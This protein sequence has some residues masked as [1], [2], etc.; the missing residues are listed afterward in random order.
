[1]IGGVQSPLLVSVFLGSAG[2]HALI[3]IDSSETHKSLVGVQV[4]S[5]YVVER[6][7]YV[8]VSVAKFHELILWG[9]AIQSE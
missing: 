4:Q 8:I 7:S 9:R 2:C 1:M 5:P 6:C 3:L